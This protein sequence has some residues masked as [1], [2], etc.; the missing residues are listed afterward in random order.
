MPVE[1]CRYVTLTGYLIIQTQSLSLLIGSYHKVR[2]HTDYMHTG[3][4]S[5][6]SVKCAIS[7]LLCSNSTFSSKSFSWTRL[8][9]RRRLFSAGPFPSSGYPSGSEG[10]LETWQWLVSLLVSAPVREV[11]VLIPDKSPNVMLTGYLIIQTQLYWLAH[12]IRWESTQTTHWEH[13]LLIQSL[14]VLN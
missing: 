4:S 1:Q 8:L 5:N 9:S 2:E 14:F 10:L 6:R 3:S 11:P 13:T 7:N 12:I